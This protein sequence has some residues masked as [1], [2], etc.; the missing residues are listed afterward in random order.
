MIAFLMLTPSSLM[1]STKVSPQFMS[2]FG[3]MHT[4][5]DI[6]AKAPV[7]RIFCF[8]I[9]PVVLLLVTNGVSGIL[10][11]RKPFNGGSKTP[12]IYGFEV[13]LHA[14]FLIWKIISLKDGRWSFPIRHLALGG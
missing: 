8:C 2:V 1:E 3:I 12:N 6:L 4:I 11:F 14:N 10:D 13:C 9:S 5:E 7:E